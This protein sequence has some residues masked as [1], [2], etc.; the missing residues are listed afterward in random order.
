MKSKAT[1]VDEILHDVDP[2]RRPFFHELHQTIIDNLPDGFEPA[3]SYGGLGYVVPHSVYPEGYHCKPQEPLPF[4]GIAAQKGSINFY[5]MG[6]YADETL[7][8][9]FVGEYSKHSSRKMDMGKSCVRF[10]KHKEIPLPLI[11]EL[12][13]KMSAVQWIQIY[14]SMYHPQKKIR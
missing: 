3:I 6:L 4:A 8:Q 1:T 11:G 9:W 10:K 5:H 12:M 2:D 13:R 14:E 7:M